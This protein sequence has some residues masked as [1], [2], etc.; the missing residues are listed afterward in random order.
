MNAVQNSTERPANLA[1]VLDG[2]TEEAI[3]AM[4]ADDSCDAI[5][6]KAENFGPVLT[7]EEMD[8]IEALWLKE[9]VNRRAAL[10]MLTKPWAELNK[11]IIEDRGFAV[12]AAQVQILAKEVNLYKALA[13][14]MEAADMRIMLALASRED[15]VEV[16]EEAKAFE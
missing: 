3:N 2:M 7:C 10:V 1:S 12:A 9:K 8:N 14:L 16:I 5:Y 11:M 4:S 15:M 6:A 13:E